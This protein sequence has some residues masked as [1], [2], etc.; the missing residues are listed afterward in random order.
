MNP[1]R[2]NFLIPQITDKINSIQYLGDKANL[3]NELREDCKFFREVM[4]DSKILNILKKIKGK[5]VDALMSQMIF[6]E[7]K[8]K[9]SLQSWQPHQDNSYPKN[10]NGHYITINIFLKN[11]NMKNGTMY[12]YEKSHTQGILQFEKKIS[13]REKD[14]KPGN[15]VIDLPFKKKNLI[16]KKGDLLILHGNLVHGSYPN[17]SNLSRPLYSVSYISSGE[18]FVPGLNAQRKIMTLNN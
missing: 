17:K 16:F 12:I 10:K 14:S 8:T 5:K 15:T 1:D 18:K 6:K 9:F 4:L 7:K 11:S 2:P 13:Y 3:L